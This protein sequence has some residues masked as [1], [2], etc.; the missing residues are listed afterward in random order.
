MSARKNLFLLFL[1]GGS[2]LWGA[3]SFPQ[4]QQLQQQQFQRPTVPD[5]R[6]IVDLKRMSSN[7][8]SELRVLEEKLAN[9]EDII[10]SI[11]K[12]L[13]NSQKLLQEGMKEKSGSADQRLTL[14]EKNLQVISTEVA[15]YKQHLEKQNNALMAL[16]E[17]I[18][19]YESSMALQSN[20]INHLQIA[21]QTLTE[22]LQGPP[23]SPTV[24]NNN[25]DLNSNSY[26]VQPGDSLGKIAVKF[27]VSLKALRE[28]NK[29]SSD[30]IIAGQTLIIPPKL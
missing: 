18:A 6:D 2:V 27:G 11:R 17:R 25:Q 22:A 24:V 5:A 19:N 13:K 8:E 10:D 1:M 30:K 29:L 14:I 15:A 26:Q 7:H 4:Q 16:H 9:Q 23:I 12:D 20:N 28:E 21:L 3:P